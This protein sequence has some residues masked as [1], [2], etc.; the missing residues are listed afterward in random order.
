[1]SNIKI[2]KWQKKK[3]YIYVQIT[4]VFKNITKVSFLFFQNI[5]EKFLFYIFCNSSKTFCNCCIF[6]KKKK[7]P[8]IVCE[9]GVLLLLPFIVG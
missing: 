3:I 8:L 5:F 1:M 7:K 9:R 4:V 6:I 2:L